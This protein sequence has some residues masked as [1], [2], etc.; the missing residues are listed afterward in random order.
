MTPVPASCCGSTIRKSPGSGA[1]ARCDVV[2]RGVAAWKGRIYVGTLDGRLA[3]SD[4]ERG[5]QTGPFKP[6]RRIVPTPRRAPPVVDGKVV[7]AMGGEYG[8]RGF[9]T[10]Y[11]AETGDQAWRF[12]TV[13]KTSTIPSRASTSR[14]P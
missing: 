8:V 10:A 13:L 12:Y 3:V 4:A 9:I 6:R 11:D 2:N 5:N 7:I 1:Y 14:Q